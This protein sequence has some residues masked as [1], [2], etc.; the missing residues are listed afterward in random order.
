MAN[1]A[2]IGQ[3]KQ[4]QFLITFPKAMAELLR[5]KKGDSVEFL[6][7]NGEVVVRKC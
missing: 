6:L 5:I 4:G 7:I 1:Q 2:K 3:T